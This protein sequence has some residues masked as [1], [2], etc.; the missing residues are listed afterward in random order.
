M[1]F[2]TSVVG[3]HHDHF[4]AYYEQDASSVA[5]ETAVACT[6]HWTLSQP[7]RRSVPA[8]PNLGPGPSDLKKRLTCD[9]TQ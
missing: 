6:A 9:V 8:R 5:V 3:K 4:S 2:I 1:V 7:R